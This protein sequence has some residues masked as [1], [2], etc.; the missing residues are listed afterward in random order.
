MLSLNGDQNISL[1]YD[2]CWLLLQSLS[3]PF[4]MKYVIFAAFTNLCRTFSCSKYTIMLD[5][6]ITRILF[7][8]MI[9]FSSKFYHYILLFITAIS[10]IF[11]RIYSNKKNERIYHHNFHYWGYVSL[12]SFNNTSLLTICIQSIIYWIGV[13]TNKSEISA[14]FPL[15]NIIKKGV[16]F[17]F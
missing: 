4:L 12:F 17:L 2:S 10:Y 8:Q 13:Y 6:F 15:L 16:T 1:A 14:F 11:M 3:N 7:I 5:L 9:R